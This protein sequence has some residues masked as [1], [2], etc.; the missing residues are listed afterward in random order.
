MKSTRGD[1]VYQCDTCTR[2]TRVPLNQYS[3]DVVQRCIITENCPGK[4]FPVKNVREINSTPAFP[5]EVP[6]LQDWFPRNILFNHPQTIANI[7]WTITHNL[8]SLPVVQ[9]L[10][11]RQLN[12]NG[13]FVQV[14][15]AP[16]QFTV[17]MVDLNTVNVFFTRSESGIAQCIG[18]ASQNLVNPQVI[19]TTV[20]PDKLLTNVGEITI[21]TASFAALISVTVVYKGNVPDTIVSYVG[22]DAAPSVNSPWV[23]ADIVH[24]GGRNYAVRSF[25]ILTNIPGPAYF[26]NGLISD[27]S[28]V[29]FTGF[30]PNI[31]ENFIL[32]GNSPFGPVDRIPD[33]VID[34]SQIDSQNPAT[35]YHLGNM[36]SNPSAIRSI[37]PPVIVVA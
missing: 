17:V 22:I 9:I 7:E 32:L 6:G 14:E 12:T 23:G 18:T 13:E 28:P 26:S 19:N 25:N 36:Y 16:D 34:I 4:L 8:G 30:S 15:L 2:R 10:V 37:Y 33:Q 20:V 21:A 11:N 27:G 29:Y 31:N 35:Y 3:F 24:I 5:L 1:V